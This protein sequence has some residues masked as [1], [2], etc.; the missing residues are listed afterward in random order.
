M[1]LLFLWKTIKTELVLGKIK[2][3][4]REQQIASKIWNISSIS[5]IFYSS[6]GTERNR[7]K[8]MQRSHCIL[9]IYWYFKRNYKEEEV[10][11]LI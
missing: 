10:E 5:K 7:G 9:D 11:N 8:P 3:K 1:D 2:T 4:R 6:K